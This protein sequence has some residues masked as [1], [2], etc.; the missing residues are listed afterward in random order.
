LRPSVGRRDD[1]EDA[2]CRRSGATLSQPV[3]PTT[4]A[5]VET[6]RRTSDL[7]RIQEAG[8]N[9]ALA[10]AVALRLVPVVLGVLGQD[11]V[12]SLDVGEDGDSLRRRV[13]FSRLRR[14]H[15]TR[16]PVEG[17]GWEQGCRA[18]AD[19]EQARQSRVDERPSLDELVQDS[20]SG[21][22]S[23]A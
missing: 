1:L 12:R 21:A 17:L 20:R 9:L 8:H 19:E 7:A 22:G 10:R 11:L 6:R 15:D 5:R 23:S 14:R 3:P 18:A 2:V 4:T 13:V 16:V